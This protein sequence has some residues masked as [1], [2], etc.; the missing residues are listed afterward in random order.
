MTPGYSQDVKQHTIDRSIDV[1]LLDQL[2]RSNTSS[3]EFIIRS[4][5]CD[6]R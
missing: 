6:N 1:F 4:C 3:Q 5:T 2:D